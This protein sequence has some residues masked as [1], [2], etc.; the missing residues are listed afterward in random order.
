[1]IDN[2][3]Y[4]DRG[5]GILCIAL[6]D[7]TCKA[8]KQE[9]KSEWWNKGVK[10]VK[11]LRGEYS[12]HEYPTPE[13]YFRFADVSILCRIIIE[14][15]NLDNVFRKRLS[16]DAL[17][18]LFVVR[19]IRNKWAHNH[20]FSIDETNIAL[21]KMEEFLKEIKNPAM[22]EEI[23][24]LR[25]EYRELSA[26][27]NRQKE[28]ELHK[29]IEDLKIRNQQLEIEK[30]KSE[31][32]SD[33]LK[34]QLNESIKGIDQMNFEINHLKEELQRVKQSQNTARDHQVQS[35]IAE[36]ILEINTK[37]SETQSSITA[38]QEISKKLQDELRKQQIHYEEV[39]REKKVIEGELS[40][41]DKKIAE[42][43]KQNS[44]KSI[45]AEEGNIRIVIEQPESAFSQ[46]LKTK[47]FFPTLIV[48]CL[49]VVL[50]SIVLLTKPKNAIP[51]EIKTIPTQVVI[52]NSETKQKTDDGV[53]EVSEASQFVDRRAT[54]RLKIASTYSGLDWAFMINSMYDYQDPDNFIVAIETETAG[55]KYKEQGITSLAELFPKGSTIL[56]TGRI[57]KYV[58]KQTGIPRYEIIVKDP[59]QIQFE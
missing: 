6:Q 41:L 20:S 29:Q 43:V 36:T 53:I 22:L 11:D 4:I 15:T 21:G 26:S 46:T 28:K 16:K 19:N 44:Q 35:Q 25:N 32:E 42:A 9:Y 55:K 34:I 24:K 13:D 47:W 2:R 48:I 50:L 5:L 57:Q 52:D 54:V 33:Y 1:M 40:N 37:L 51:A 7:F 27:S 8:I 49:A 17:T 23:Q 3:S 38:Q 39:Q 45:K 14:K 12:Y 30:E 58:D 10:P 56:V 18:N 59:G 31:K